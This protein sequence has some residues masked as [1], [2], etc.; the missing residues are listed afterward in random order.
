VLWHILVIP[1]AEV[2]TIEPRRPAKM[3][4]RDSLKKKERKET[5][6]KERTN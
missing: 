3:T 6:M 4:Q 1:V 5:K 2:E